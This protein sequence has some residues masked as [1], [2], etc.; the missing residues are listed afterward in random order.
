MKRNLIAPAL[1][2]ISLLTMSQT[3]AATLVPY[4]ACAGGDCKSFTVMNYSAAEISKIKPASFCY[5]KGLLLVVKDGTDSEGRE[6]WHH[7]G[8]FHGYFMARDCNK[9]DN[10][11]ESDNWPFINP[12]LNEAYDSCR[13]EYP[14]F[15]T[16][17]GKP[18]PNEKTL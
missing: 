13:S 6:M 10:L 8:A 14:C 16:L 7:E 2:V 9:M 17:E 15:T 1:I 12:T 3:E 11:P 4:K 5:R 18:R